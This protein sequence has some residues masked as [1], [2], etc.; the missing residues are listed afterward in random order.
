MRIKRLL[1]TFPI[2]NQV[3]IQIELPWLF[4]KLFQIVK[5][6]YK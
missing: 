1:K 2:K 4:F 5:N 3:Q 6:Q